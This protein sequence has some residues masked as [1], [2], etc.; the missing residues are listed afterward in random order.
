MNGFIGGGQL[1]YNWQAGSFVFG[2]EADFDYM[3]LRGSRLS[4]QQFPSTPGLPFFFTTGTS[5]STDWLF[6]LRARAGVT[7]GNILFY[8]TGGLAV[9]NVGFNQT[10]HLLA[11]FVEESSVSATKA[12]WTV[13]GGAEI[14]LDRHWSAKAEYLYVDLGKVESTGTLVPPFPGAFLTNSA[15]LTTNIFRVGLNYKFG[16]EREYAPLK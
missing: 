16:G 1:G 7:V 12:G 13:G 4:T 8:G 9:G 3:G 6:T 2:G 11:P 14:A 15:Q 5:A 10:I